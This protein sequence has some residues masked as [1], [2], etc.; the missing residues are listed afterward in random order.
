MDG[1]HQGGCQRRARARTLQSQ[2]TG[3][4]ARCPLRAGRLL[5]ANTSPSLAYLWRLVQK[6]TSTKHVLPT[7]NSFMQNPTRRHR[8][9]G[10]WRRPARAWGPARVQQW[11]FW[12]PTHRPRGFICGQRASSVDAFCAM[13]RA[14]QQQQREWQIRGSRSSGYR[15]HAWARRNRQ[16]MHVHLAGRRNSWPHRSAMWQ[17]ERTTM[18]YVRA[19]DA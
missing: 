18:W 14:T 7:A 17:E 11:G 5:L 2:N 3:R 15:Q 19:C 12:R 13:H 9:K 8:W 4:G 10:D 6:S 1:R 16:E